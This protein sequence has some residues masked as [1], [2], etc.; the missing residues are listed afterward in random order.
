MCK[1][2][3]PSRSKY[4]FRFGNDLQTYIGCTVIWLP[5]QAV[6]VVAIGMDAVN[7][8]SPFLVGQDPLGKLKM[9][10]NNVRDVL[11]C[12]SVKCIVSLV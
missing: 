9:V 2:L 8:N 11:K 1:K 12:D 10:V 5:I 4:K 7:A 3:K 6:V